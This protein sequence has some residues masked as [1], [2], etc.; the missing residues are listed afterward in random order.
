VDKCEVMIADEEMVVVVLFVGAVGAVIC[1]LVR[2]GL[3]LTVDSS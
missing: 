2:I 1:R 3:T